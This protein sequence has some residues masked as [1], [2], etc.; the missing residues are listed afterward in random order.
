[1]MWDGVYQSAEVLGVFRTHHHA[2]PELDVAAF[3]DGFAAHGQQND[4][5]G[6]NNSGGQDWPPKGKT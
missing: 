1:M 2:M 4:G 3:A 5:D 6:Q